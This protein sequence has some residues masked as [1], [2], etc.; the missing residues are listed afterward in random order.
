MGSSNGYEIVKKDQPYIQILNTGRLH[1]ICAANMKTHRKSNAS[2]YIY[3]SL[4]YGKIAPLVAHQIA[5]FSFVK[6][7]V[8]DVNIQRV[9]QQDN[10]VDCGL[11]ALAF[12]TSLAFGDDPSLIVYDASKLRQHLLNCLTNNEVTRFPT[13]EEPLGY[14]HRCRRKRIEIELFC[15]CRMPHDAQ[16]DWDANQDMAQCDKCKDWFHRIC[17]KIPSVIFENA[18]KKMDL[19]SCK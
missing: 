14:R 5:N 3:D 6:E 16:A 2:T 8:I 19:Q 11:Y 7:S 13:T 12:A 9:Q 17:E 18:R 4:N 1:W 10:S 15:S